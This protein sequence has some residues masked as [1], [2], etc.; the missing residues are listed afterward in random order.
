MPRKRR[1]KT[2]ARPERVF[3]A[4]QTSITLG[5][6][7]TLY[8]PAHLNLPYWELPMQVVIPTALGS[9]EDRLSH[10][11]FVFAFLA[12]LTGLVF[13]RYIA[14]LFGNIAGASAGFEDPAADAAARTSA[15]RIHRP[16]DCID[17]GLRRPASRL[18]AVE[19][20]LCICLSCGPL[21]PFPQCRPS[22][23]LVPGVVCRSPVRRRTQH[24]PVHLQVV[25]VA[26]HR[27]GTSTRATWGTASLGSSAIG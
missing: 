25:P 16:D 14:R 9:S 18:A 17:G 7:C 19:K 13:N 1:R 24:G 2:D 15:G 12:S 4:C 21:F 22:S 5:S 8:R 20:V 3:H 27:R 23:A 26:S 11:A 6:L 10:F